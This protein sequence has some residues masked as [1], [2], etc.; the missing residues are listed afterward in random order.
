M[1]QDKTENFQIDKT[2]ISI[3]SLLSKDAFMPYTEIA[4]RLLVSGGT[5][6][7]RMRRME[8]AGI[9]KGTTVVVDHARLGFD[10]TAF[11]GVYLQKGSIYHKVIG[12]LKQVREVVEAH[13]TTGTYSVFLKVICRNTEHLRKVLNDEIQV[14]EGIERTDT[15]L[16]L[17]ESI[18][19]PIDL[20]RMVKK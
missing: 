10:L 20:G 7:V 13:Y 18:I 8:K 19:R 12:K 4:K 6:H 17:E 9:V 1:D 15:I 3:L 5:I 11:I 14:I 16:S 2:D